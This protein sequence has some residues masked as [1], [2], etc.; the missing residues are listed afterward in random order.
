MVDRE[1]LYRAHFQLLG[2]TPTLNEQ[3]T[4]DVPRINEATD[5]NLQIANKGIFAIKSPVEGLQGEAHGVPP[6]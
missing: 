2:Q 1:R 6:C 3:L 4:P 5:Q